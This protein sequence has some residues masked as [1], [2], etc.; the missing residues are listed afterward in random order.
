MAEDLRAK[1]K[2]PCFH[3]FTAAAA[4]VVEVQLPPT[5][6]KVSVG[7]QSGATVYIATDGAVDAGAPPSH[8]AWS[9]SGALLALQLSNGLRRHD[10]VF[11]WVS[12]GPNTVHVILED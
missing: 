5:A 6:S 1:A 9:P 8:Y 2:F 4:T 7:T 10:S 3:I 12:S 11:V